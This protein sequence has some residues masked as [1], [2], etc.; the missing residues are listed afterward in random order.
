MQIQ[1]SVVLIIAT[2]LIFSI[3]GLRKERERDRERNINK[4]NG[5]F[6]KGTIN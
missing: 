1:Y 2:M 3:G 5:Q 4:N 6:G